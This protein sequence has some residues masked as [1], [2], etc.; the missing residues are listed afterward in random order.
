VRGI[1]AVLR[2]VLAGRRRRYACHTCGERYRVAHRCAA[3]PRA[4]G[5]PVPG[6]VAES[7]AERGERP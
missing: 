4:T 1:V 6:V 7:G 2:I 5:E 3:T